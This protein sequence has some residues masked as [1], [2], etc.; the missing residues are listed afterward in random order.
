MVAVLDADCPSSWVCSLCV[1]LGSWQSA[2]LT[3]VSHCADPR[4][5]AH[6]R[7]LHD[8]LSL[9]VTGGFAG[10]LCLSAS[11]QYCILF[12]NCTRWWGFAYRCSFCGFVSTLEYTSSN[13]PGSFPS[14]CLRCV[15][16]VGKSLGPPHPPVISD[17]PTVLWFTLLLY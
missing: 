1:C 15:R 17:K 11:L 5:A 4:V 8:A 6:T 10:C 16:T 13:Q 7:R 3:S 9:W 12:W 14:K 2:L